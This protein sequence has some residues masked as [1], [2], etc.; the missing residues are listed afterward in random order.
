MTEAQE[1]ENMDSGS[2]AG[3]IR[4][5]QRFPVVGQ[6]HVMNGRGARGQRRCAGVP[7]SCY[8]KCLMFEALAS[9][10]GIAHVSLR[11]GRKD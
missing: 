6:R 1:L 7:G 4:K 3:Q 2:T 10:S 5:G 9:K 11:S 8:F